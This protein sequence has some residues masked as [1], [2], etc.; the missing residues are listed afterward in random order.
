MLYC[1]HQLSDWTMREHARD[2]GRKIIL[3]AKP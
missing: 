3:A 1:G 2:P